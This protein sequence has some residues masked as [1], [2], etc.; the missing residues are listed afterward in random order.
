[1]PLLGRGEKEGQATIGNSL[2]WSVHKPVG[3]EGKV[4]LQRLWAA[5]SLLLI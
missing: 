1:M 4:A 2:L 5:R 3:L